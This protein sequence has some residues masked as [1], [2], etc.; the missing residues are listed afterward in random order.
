[1]T[2]EPLAPLDGSPRRLQSTLLLKVPRVRHGLTS[3]VPGL[4]VADGN[5]AYSPPRD[6]ADAWEMRRLFCEDL[7]LDPEHIITVGQVHGANV[8]P[9]DSSATGLG[10]KPG[11]GRAGLGDAV[12][13]ADPGPVL[14]TLHADCLPLLLV[15]PRL[16]AVACVHAG[17]R[18]TVADVAG[19]TVRAMTDAFDTR[20]ADLLAFLGPSIGRCC[21]Q[22]GDEVVTAWNAT[23]AEPASHAI[24]YIAGHPHLDLKRAN[25][26]LLQR[27]GLRS[28]NMET[29]PICTRCEGSN[30]FSHRGQGPDTGRFGAII[31]ID[32]SH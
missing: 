20:P 23:A 8:I 32:P 29:S 11:A 4:G 30:W 16:P 1:L 2:A 7:G 12:I 9:V 3:R 21:Y 15:D 27:A 28:E 6:A 25:Q 19:A 17:W 18:G 26:I 14:L 5:V 10:A 24:E 13:T 22:V 31:A